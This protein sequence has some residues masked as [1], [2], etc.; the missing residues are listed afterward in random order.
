MT[1]EVIFQTKINGFAF[2]G[3]NSCHSVHSS[4][5]SEKQERDSPAA[6]LA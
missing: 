3:E 6:H 4:D 5:S 2:F 1:E